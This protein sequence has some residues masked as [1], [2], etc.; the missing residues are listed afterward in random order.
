[1]PSK[2]RDNFWLDRLRQRVKPHGVGVHSERLCVLQVGSG[3]TTQPGIDLRCNR[4]QL[5]GVPAT[6]LYPCD[7]ICRRP[8]LSGAKQ[9]SSERNLR[10]A[11]RA[12]RGIF[13][14]EREC[15]GRRAEL[16]EVIDRV[17]DA[18]FREA[19]ET[20]A[21]NILGAL[22]PSACG[23]GRGDRKSVV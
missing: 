14:R 1:M 2:H 15:F 3:S 20:L 6:G 12:Q 13:L 4:M 8:G 5:R 19:L 22:Y 11:I 7:A 21:I 17:T 16:E 10:V 9:G 18:R 23:L